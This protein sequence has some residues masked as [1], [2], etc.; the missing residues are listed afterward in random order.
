VSNGSPF[1]EPIPLD[2]AFEVHR[3][4]LDFRFRPG[5]TPEHWI[6]ER[7]IDGVWEH[8]CTYDLRPPEPRERD[9]IYQRHHTPG[10]S[11]VMD[12]FRLIR[13]REDEVYSLYN[14]RLV[15]FTATGKDRQPVSDM[16]CAA[17]AAGVFGMPG[18][19]IEGALAA[20]SERERMP[21]G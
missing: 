18:L 2:R 15:H 19:P 5:A 16:E 21:T 13:C 10:E 14:G 17:F 1:F 20:L 11:W 4:G 12:R 3:I 8:F 9:A 6:Q 7:R